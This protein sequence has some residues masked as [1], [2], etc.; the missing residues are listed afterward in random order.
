MKRVFINIL[1][2]CVLA[3]SCGGKAAPEKGFVPLFNGSDLTGWER[4]EGFRVKEGCIFST[5]ENGGNMF[6]REDFGNYILRL[7]YMLST[8]GNSGVVVRG[9]PDSAWQTGFEVQLLAPWTPYRDDLHCTGSL[10]G[11]VAVTNRP[12]ET[13]GIWHSLEIVC[14]RKTI[15]VSADGQAVSWADMDRV[16]TLKGKNLRGRIGLQGNHSEPKEWVKIRNMRIRDLDR[17]PSYVARGFSLTDPRLRRET[18][19]A[20]VRLG[21]PLVP[22][23]CG[24]MAGPDST[25]PSAARQALFSIAAE[26]SSPDYPA[27]GRDSM[28]GLLEE[29]ADSTG[30]TVVKGYLEWLAGMLKVKQ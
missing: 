12:D 26:T 5:G 4:T 17:E 14:D 11:Y 22:L 30:S 7:D 15:I 3:L 27:A 29:Q 23:L 6:T 20:A 9:D 28:V 2:A 10:Y 13:T 18:Y 16:E 8:V 25:V 1:L 24:L 21:R 19:S